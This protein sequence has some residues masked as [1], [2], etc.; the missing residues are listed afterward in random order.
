MEKW[1]PNERVTFET[2][3]SPKEVLGWVREKQTNNKQYHGHIGRVFS[4]S[5]CFFKEKERK[6]RRGGLERG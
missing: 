3:V 6:E 2:T 1:N 4:N 5:L